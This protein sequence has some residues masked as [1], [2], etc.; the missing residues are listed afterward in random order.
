AALS[1]SPSLPLAEG[2]TEMP[3][4]TVSGTTIPLQG[5]RRRSQRRV[6]WG[7][8]GATVAVVL[9]AAAVL[10]PDKTVAPTAA[11]ATVAPTSPEAAPSPTPAD[12]SPVALAA[13]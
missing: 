8:A 5:R 7:A 9:G 13:P 11:T 12:S 3:S 1:P 6:F 4:A 2:I 10:W